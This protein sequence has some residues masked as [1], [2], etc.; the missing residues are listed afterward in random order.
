MTVFSH[1]M[2]SSSK[3]IMGAI[4]QQEK[5]WPPPIPFAKACKSKSKMTT[6]SSGTESNDVE[7]KTK[8]LT[9]EIRFEPRDPDSQTYEEKSINTM[10][11]VHPKRGFVIANKLR[12]SSKKQ[13]LLETTLTMSLC[14]I[15]STKPL[16]ESPQRRNTPELIICAQCRI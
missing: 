11:M 12:S 15:A 9:V 8:Y 4:K 14:V 3:E 7:D 6:K 16:C 2:N 5:I 10:V 13:R 1:P